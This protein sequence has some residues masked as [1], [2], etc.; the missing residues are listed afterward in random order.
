MAAQPAC[1]H[2]LSNWLSQRFA[3]LQVKISH[4]Q[5]AGLGQTLKSSEGQR[6]R[7]NVPHYAT[8]RTNRHYNV[9]NSFQVT[10]YISHIH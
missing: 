7:S 8:Y 1:C 3:M 6:P 5:G 10:G 9:T 2:P 4:K